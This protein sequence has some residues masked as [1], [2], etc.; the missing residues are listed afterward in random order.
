MKKKEYWV[1]K[2][3]ERFGLPDNSK[4]I[5]F[6]NPEEFRRI[7]LERINPNHKIIMYGYLKRKFHNRNRIKIGKIYLPS[8]PMFV[9][10]LLGIKDYFHALI[11]SPEF[12]YICT[13]CFSAYILLATL[14]AILNIYIF[15]VTYLIAITHFKRVLHVKWI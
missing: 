9:S 14:L 13:C 3:K 2:I 4:L 7:E 15:P 1:H 12:T 10:L 8:Y 11:C 5:F 6:R